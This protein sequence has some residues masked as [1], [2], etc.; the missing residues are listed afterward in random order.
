[1][2]IFIFILGISGYLISKIFFEKNDENFKF[3][4]SSKYVLKK[5]ESALKTLNLTTIDDQ[6]I[7]FDPSEA[8]IVILN[9]WAPWCGPCVDEFPSLISLRKKFST[10]EVLIIGIIMDEENSQEQLKK[11]IEVHGLNFPNVF[12]KSGM[13]Y[14]LFNITS[15]P[16]TIIFH[17]GKILDIKNGE[18]DFEAIEFIETLEKLLNKN[19][20]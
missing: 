7:S 13:I 19:I 20:A 10:K 6:K 9:F 2:P 11:T 14:N 8:P 5:Y 4:L 17:Q 1:M 18:K 16:A 12:D 15:I 3:P